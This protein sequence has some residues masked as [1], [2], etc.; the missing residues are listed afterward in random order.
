MKRKE[1]FC[2][3]YINKILIAGLIISL[4]CNVF[5]AIY[6]RNNILK[7]FRFNTAI[8][9][10]NIPKQSTKESGSDKLSTFEKDLLQFNKEPYLISNGKISTNH[11]F[12]R[13]I[14]ILILG[15]SISL[16]GVPDEEPDKTPRGLVSSDVNHDYAHILMNRISKD[17]DVNIKY[18]I[19]NS[20]DFERTFE[21]RPFNFATLSKADVKNPDY[22]IVQLGEN[23]F[24][25]A[26]KTYEKLLEERYS[27]IF[28]RFPYATKIVCIPFYP[29]ADKQRIITKIAIDN[30]AF[31]IDLS[32]LGNGTDKKNFAKSEKKYKQEG[33]DVH[34]G[35]YGMKNIADTIY[36]LFNVII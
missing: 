17:K 24:N 16:T 33:V 28:Q 25:Y 5:V 18:S 23:V 29:D 15:N 8:V 22:L 2:G 7:I 19:V 3:Q 13:T 27:E 34:P 20:A 30:Q 11:I 6:Y 35:N 9:S 36:S 31:L 21:K 1:L 32:H 4:L 12:T 14:K 26:A 10:T